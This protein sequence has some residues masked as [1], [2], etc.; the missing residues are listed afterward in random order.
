[1]LCRQLPGLDSRTSEICEMKY[2]KQHTF[3][4]WVL[5][6]FI[7]YAGLPVWMRDMEV[8]AL[9][10]FPYNA[11]NSQFKSIDETGNITTKRRNVK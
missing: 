8:L 4:L 11:L 9:Q 5:L 7:C 1:M 2:L 3:V 10:I 6:C